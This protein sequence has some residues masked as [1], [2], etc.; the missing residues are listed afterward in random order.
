[1]EPGKHM[2]PLAIVGFDIE[3]PQGVVSEDDFWEKVVR[4]ECCMEALPEDRLNS[5]GFYHS[6]VKQR[7]TVSCQPPHPAN[8]LPQRPFTYRPSSSRRYRFLLQVPPSF[9]VTLAHLTHLSFQSLLQ[10]PLEW[11]RNNDGCSKR[12]IMLSKMVGSRNVRS[13]SL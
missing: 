13:D 3:F 11:I 7:D 10:R 12:L 8:G 5:S 4:R 1:M 6:D 2:E 9:V